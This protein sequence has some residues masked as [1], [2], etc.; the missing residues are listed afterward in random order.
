MYKILNDAHQ[1]RVS[2]S[3]FFEV[4][5]DADLGITGFVFPGMDHLQ[6]CLSR[7]ENLLSMEVAD[8]GQSSIDSLDR[9]QV[10]NEP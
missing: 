3:S 7:F 10:K 5:I 8:D 2:V 6:Y 9:S 4:E 1:W